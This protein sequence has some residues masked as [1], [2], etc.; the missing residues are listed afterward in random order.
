MSV[1]IGSDGLPAKRSTGFLFHNSDFVLMIAIIWVMENDLLVLIL[2][3][4]LVWSNRA[5]Y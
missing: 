5:G 2:V 3:F 1:A 4:A